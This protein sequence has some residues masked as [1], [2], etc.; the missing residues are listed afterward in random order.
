MVLFRPFLAPPSGSIGPLVGEILALPLGP[1]RFATG[2]STEYDHRVTVLSDN[3]T[4]VAYISRQDG[5]R[6]RSLLDKAGS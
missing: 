2:W 1:E 5:T 3:I 6:W 4:T